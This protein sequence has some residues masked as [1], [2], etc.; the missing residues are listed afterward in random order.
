L[1]EEVAEL[2]LGRAEGAFCVGDETTGDVEELVAEG[3][4]EIGG[5]LLGA[6][7][8]LGGQGC[9]RPEGLHGREELP[10]NA[11]AEG[12]VYEDSTNFR[13][14]HTLEAVGPLLN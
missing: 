4:L 8:L 1:E 12:L 11:A 14:A 13:G 3:L 7:F 5:Q 10:A 9:R 6:G 2:E